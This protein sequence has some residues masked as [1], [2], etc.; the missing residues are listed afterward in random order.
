MIISNHFL[1][2]CI[3]VTICLF[4]CLSLFVRIVA[5]ELNKWPLTHI[6]GTVIHPDTTSGKFEGQ[7]HRS[8]SRSQ[9]VN[10]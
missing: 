1:Y 3:C 4:V 5:S 2:V 9:E 8:S 6:F 10:A 7:S